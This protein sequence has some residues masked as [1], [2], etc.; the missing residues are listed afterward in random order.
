MRRLIVPRGQA[1]DLIED[2]SLVS[3]TPARKWIFNRALTS[4]P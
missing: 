4:L 2:Q 1:A 3:S